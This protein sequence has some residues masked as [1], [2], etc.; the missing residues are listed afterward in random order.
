MDHTDRFGF[1]Q[2]VRFD[3]RN[4]DQNLIFWGKRYFPD[5][6]ENELILLGLFSQITLFLDPYPAPFSDPLKI[7]HFFT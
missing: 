7:E 6:W 3:D 5:Y 2:K 4:F 1:P